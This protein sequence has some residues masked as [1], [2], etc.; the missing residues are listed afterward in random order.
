MQVPLVHDLPS[1]RFFSRAIR[2]IVVADRTA[3]IQRAFDHTC[4][5]EVRELAEFDRQLAGEAALK[6]SLKQAN[7][8]VKPSC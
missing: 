8:L 2:S 6:R 4:R 7:A 1:L 5:H 3:A